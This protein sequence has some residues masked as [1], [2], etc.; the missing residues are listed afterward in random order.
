[1]LIY[2]YNVL[3]FHLIYP[4]CIYISLY[5]TLLHSFQSA[6]YTLNDEQIAALKNNEIK[7]LQ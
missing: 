5:I 6:A 4:G 2:I 3:H 1:M 7:Y